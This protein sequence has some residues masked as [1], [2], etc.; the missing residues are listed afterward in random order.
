MVAS[1]GHCLTLGIRD[2]ET[3]RVRTVVSGDCEIEIRKS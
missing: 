2:E 3:S 1:A